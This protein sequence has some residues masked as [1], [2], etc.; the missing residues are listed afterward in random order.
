MHFEKIAPFSNVLELPGDKSI[1]HRALIFAAMADGISLIKNLSDGKDVNSTKK[2]LMEM[3]VPF[4][5]SEGIVEVSGLGYKG[6]KSPDKVL[7][8]GNSGTTARLLSG[9]LACQNFSSTLTGDK[10]LCRRPMERVAHPLNFMGLKVKT[11]NKSLPL[12][13]YKNNKLHP[14]TYTLETPSAQVKSALI[15]AGLHCLEQSVI[16]DPFN[17]R[18]HTER[19]LGLSCEQSG[20]GKVISVS[21]SNYPKLS[22]FFI[23][24]DISTASFFIVLTLLSKNSFLKIK[25]VSLNPTRT[26]ILDILIRMG[27]KIE[28]SNKQSNNQEE[29]GD[30]TISSSELHNS[31]IF[32]EE[33]PQIIDEIPILAV[34]GFFANGN[35]EIRNAEELRYKESDRIKS[36]CYNFNKLGA[37]IEEHF[38]G[39][40]IMDKKSKVNPEFL[41]FKDHR[42]AMAFSILSMI[43]EQGGTIKGFDCVKISNPG[44]LNQLEQI[45]T[46]I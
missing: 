13:F 46:Q 44:F 38:D 27:G 6:L 11:T 8:A 25:N 28:I 43:L 39:F 14:V 7:N 9:L 30:V 37:S 20:E 41:S 42:I 17:T 32:K 12:I 16:I 24:S 21:K 2:C 36:I 10:S 33:I 4:S 31:E 35:F 34:A 5:N 15:I 19:M 23:P 26:K 40:I 45:L 29:Y 22:S 3:G 1:S 18:D